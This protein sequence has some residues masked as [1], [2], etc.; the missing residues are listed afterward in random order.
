MINMHN[1]RNR[2]NTYGIGTQVAVKAQSYTSQL[3]SKLND[4]R[5]IQANKLIN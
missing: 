5:G 3:F 2:K 4:K 1:Y